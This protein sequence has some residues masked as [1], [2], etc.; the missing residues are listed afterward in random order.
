M[1]IPFLGSRGGDTPFGAVLI[2]PIAD[3]DPKEYFTE[4]QMAEYEAMFNRFDTDQGGSIG[5]EELFRLFLQLGIKMSRPQLE[6]V[7]Q[8]VD[9]DGSGEIDL[10]EFLVLMIKLLGSRPRADL[11]DY[12][13]WCDQKTLENIHKVFRKYD[14]SG[15]GSIDYAELCQLLKDMGMKLSPPQVEEIC[16]EVDKD[17]SGEIE[18]DEFAAMWVVL[19]RRNKIINPREYMTGDQITSYFKIFTMFDTSGDGSIEKEELDNLFRR[20]GIVLKKEQLDALVKQYD[21]DGSGEFDFDEFCVMMIK[22]KGMK[23]HRRL[24]VQTSSVHDLWV[25]GLS[26]REI[27]KVG[28]DAE[29]M[30]D[31][32]IPAGKLYF[33]KV[34]KEQIFTPLELRRAGYGAAE[35]RKGGVGLSAL[36]YCGYSS[37]DL[38][39]AGFSQAGMRHANRKLN[40]AISEGNF[41]LL[42]QTHPQTPIDNN[43]RLPYHMT[44]RIRQN[45]EYRMKQS[46]G[47]PPTKVEVAATCIGAV[48][49]FKTLGKRGSVAS[50]GSSATLS[51][52]GRSSLVRTTSTDMGIGKE[53]S[54][55]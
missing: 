47:R 12:K 44:P 29:A 4:E 7:V 27:K 22:L 24:T 45:T 16:K 36:R 33:D 41:S 17:G 40:R 9:V 2:M 30:R 28:F 51:G 46:K 49:K 15:D 34:F 39:R 38:Q 19:A 48:S 53:V 50:V 43:C 11:I 32:G 54:F 13:E 25:E 6:A 10:E 21:V 37:L 55:A 52:A 3:I 14:T 23:R 31:A 5:V 18:F 1:S 35:L 26:V 20:L 8:E 42:A